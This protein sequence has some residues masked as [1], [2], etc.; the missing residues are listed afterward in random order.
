MSKLSFVCSALLGAMLLLGCNQQENSA[1]TKPS[2]APKSIRLA[3]IPK[4]TT[5]VYWKS[6]EAGARQAAKDL[7]VEMVWKGPLKEN[8][9]EQQISI[10]E[11]FVSEGVSGIVLAPLDE[12]A[13][14]RPV[15]EAQDKKIPVVI[16]DSALRG[17][18]GDD[19]VSLIATNNHEGGVTAGKRLAATL[20]GKGKVVLMRYLE[21]SASTLEREQGFLDAMKQNPGITVLVNNR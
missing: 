3:V 11:Q 10:V 2:D 16:I 15:K 5:H 13:L 20:D 17:K 9:R 8:D 12:S 4:G 21:G 1:T 19:F 14:V 6:V 18:A 7:N